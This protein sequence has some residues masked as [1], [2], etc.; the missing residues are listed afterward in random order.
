[1]LEQID[2]RLAATLGAERLRRLHGSLV[3]VIGTGLLGGQLLPHLAM[4]QVQQLLVDGGEVEPPNLG[5]QMF[6]MAALGEAKVAARAAQVAAFN[7]SCPVRSFHA[8]VE[9]LGL[10]V[11]DGVDLLLTGLDGRASRIAVRNVSQRLAIP[12]IDAAV[13]GSGERLLGTVTC[14]DPR[15]PSSPCY[16]CKYDDDALAAIAREGRGRGCPSWRGGDAPQTA[17]TLTASP[18]G[19]VVAGYQMIWALRVLLGE[20]GALAGRQLQIAADGE[21]RV[22]VVELAY[23]ERCRFDHRALRPLARA[24]EPT[25]GALVA[26]APAELGAE[27]DALQLHDRLAARGLVCAACGARSAR[28]RLCRAYTDDELRCACGA[29]EEMV[30]QELVARL[31]ADELRALA[32]VRFRDLGMPERDVVTVTSARGERHYLVSGEAT[33]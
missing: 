6:P 32:G 15:E 4:L 3:A 29:A 7:P 18:F 1:M 27:P 10:G 23:A 31:D 20:G 5:N 21:P 17:P 28:V 16:A 24:A 8:R 22:R 9:D 12:W 13:D 2:A 33:A 26:R 25:V 19:A 30:P 11:F 14:Y